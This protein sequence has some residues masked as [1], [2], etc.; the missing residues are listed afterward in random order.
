M[1]MVVSILITMPELTRTKFATKSSWAI[2]HVRLKL[3]NVVSSIS[4]MT[5][6]GNRGKDNLQNI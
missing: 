6:P 1:W 3:R 5:T 4:D 2:G